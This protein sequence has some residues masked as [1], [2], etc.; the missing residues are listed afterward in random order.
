MTDKS[1]IGAEHLDD[2][3][4]RT[5]LLFSDFPTESKRGA[6]FTDALIRGIAIHLYD[7]VKELEQENKALRRSLGASRRIRARRR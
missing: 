5:R 6:W 1:L 7:R 3:E 4:L 2:P